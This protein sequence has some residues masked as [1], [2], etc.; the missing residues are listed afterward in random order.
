MTPSPSGAPSNF[1][2]LSSCLLLWHI[3]GR[4]PLFGLAFA[5]TTQLI[6]TVQH[7]LA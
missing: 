7:G 4:G 6:G 5:I 3:G 2:F 1:R